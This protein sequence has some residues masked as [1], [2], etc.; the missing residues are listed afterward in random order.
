MNKR[1][2][3]KK[4]YRILHNSTPLKLDCGVLCNKACCKGDEET[5]MYLFP[6]E[7]VMYEAV[8][9]LLSIKQTTQRYGSNVPVKLA[10]CRGDCNRM[11]RP[12]ACRIFPLTPYISSEGT[13]SVKTDVRAKA[14]CPIAIHSNTEDINPFFVRN[15]YKVFRLLIDDKNVKEFIE[16]LSNLQDEYSPFFDSN[17]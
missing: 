17:P 12:L 11:L 10:V 9:Q 15:V 5:G 16:Y 14:L 1:L 6:G 13:L 4:A 3:Y 2:L 7:E 8:P